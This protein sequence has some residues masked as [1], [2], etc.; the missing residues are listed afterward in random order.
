[1]VSRRVLAGSGP[2]LS[3]VE[4]LTDTRRRGHCRCP[5]LLSVALRCRRDALAT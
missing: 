4:R 2:A 3:V 1:V 5:R